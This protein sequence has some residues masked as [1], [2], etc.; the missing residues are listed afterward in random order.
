MHVRILEMLVHLI[1]C[2]C[3]Y[4]FYVQVIELSTSICIYRQ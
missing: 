2:K 4:K 3:V 1:I